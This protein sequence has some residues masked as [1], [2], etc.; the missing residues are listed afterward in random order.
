[1]VDSARTAMKVYRLYVFQMFEQ[2][3][4]YSAVVYHGYDAGII[5]SVTLLNK[6]P[7]D[8][9]RARDFAQYSAIQAVSAVHLC[10]IGDK[11]GNDKK[12]FNFAENSGE[13]TKVYILISKI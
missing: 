8:N 9:S 11:T 10:N 12:M 2:I 1:M 13:K 4:M 5:T 3:L 7:F 6:F